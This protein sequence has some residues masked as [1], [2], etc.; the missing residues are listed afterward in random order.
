MGALSIAALI[1]AIPLVPILTAY[2]LRFILKNAGDH[3]RRKTSARRDLVLQRVKIEEQQV[4]SNLQT[5]QRT[6]DE[7]WERVESHAAGTAI[8][9][10]VPQEKDYE[11]VIGFLHPFWYGPDHHDRCQLTLH[12]NAG[13]GGER[14]LWAAIRATQQRWPRAVCIVYSGD[15][16]VDKPAMIKRV[17]NS[18][19]I[20][21]HPPTLVFLYLS[22]RHL[23]LAS[24]YPHFTLLGQSFGSLVL[25]YDAL[26]LLVPDILIDTM[27]YAFT[28]AFAK[29]LLPKMPVG[30]YVHYPVISA[31]MLGSLDDRSGD[32]GVNAG[33]GVGLRGQVK[34]YY[35][36]LFARV[37]GWVG[38]HVDVVMCNST[39]T[40]GHIT[41]LWKSKSTPDSFAKVVYPPCPVEEMERKIDVSVQ[42]EKDRKHQI[43]Y[44][45]Q[46]RPEKNHPL[47]LRSFAAYVRGLPDDSN[48]PQLV[49][50]GSVRSNTPDEL[51]IYNLRLQAHELA[52]D[53]LTEFITDA[54]FSTILEYL[55]TA[56]I[57][58]N[59]MWNE[60][61]GIGV[62]ECL[63]AGLIPVVHDS[64]GPKLDIVVPYEDQPTGY[65]AE[66][67]ED[68]ARGFQRVMQMAAEER[69][70]M[71]VRGRKVARRFTE[72][73][74]ARQWVE[75]VGKLVSMQSA[76]TAS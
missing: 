30:A 58:T 41:A 33:A 45:A 11:G 20:T 46:F 62:V 47:I 39:W 27:G 60:H 3:L 42:A 61:F 68:F 19:G 6:E 18:F 22:T 35:W 29:Y 23:V 36:H 16:D 13:G 5:S 55:Q 31:D 37:Y 71:R 21:L 49:L 75:E 70:A 24:T 34:K 69:Y 73:A 43:L 57:G 40:K 52:I 7:D 8:G 1:A 15:H 28:L 17:A 2:I 44:I 9:G 50:I 26:G 72:E 64:G 48:P 53:K 14:V 66:T 10:D 51:H 76:R 65:H 25:A 54:P 67:A 38:S 4:R 32:R 12:S 56:S 63:A 59:G 74:F